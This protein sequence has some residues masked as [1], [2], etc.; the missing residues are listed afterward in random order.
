MEDTK[1]CP[2]CGGEIKAVAKK[3]KHCGKWLVEGD[4]NKDEQTDLQNDAPEQNSKTEMPGNNIT[5]VSATETTEQSASTTNKKNEWKYIWIVMALFALV[6]IIPLVKNCKV[7]SKSVTEE[8]GNTANDNQR[9][10][11]DAKKVVDMLKEA[12]QVDDA[13]QEEI[14]NRVKVIYTDVFKYL[15]RKGYD[16]EK[17]YFTQELYE[18]FSTAR[19]IGEQYKE[20]PLSHNFWIQQSE[21]NDLSYQ[22]VSIN[23]DAYVT[24]E[25]D[26]VVNDGVMVVNL[27]L[28]DKYPNDTRHTQFALKVK[29]ENGKWMVDDLASS[30]CRSEK[31]VLAKFIESEHGIKEDAV[32]EVEGITESDLVRLF[33]E[34][35]GISPVESG[36]LSN[37]EFLNR[38]SMLIGSSNYSKLKS[39][40]T[41]YSLTVQY[42]NNGKYGFQILDKDDQDVYFV[43]YDT[44]KDNLT[45][46]LRNNSISD[47]SGQYR[48]EKADRSLIDNFTDRPFYQ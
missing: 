19:E 17:K 44:V 15:G 10:F 13:T 1:K 8:K 32:N 37:T 4:I 31:D 12:Q 40:R 5:Q 3:C 22:I 28:I 33:A 30:G 23:K 47:E 29:Q 7:E 48:Q 27:D 38:F 25:Y 34:E 46:L 41:A 11:V 16:I 2:Y 35:V 43:I 21:W 18:V 42:D 39:N 20:A 24:A 36:V 14:A 6:C 45:V 9:N 26:V